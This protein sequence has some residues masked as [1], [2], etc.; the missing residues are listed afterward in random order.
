MNKKG[1][2]YK[3]LW[4]T[5]IR[6]PYIAILFLI[7]VYLNNSL[8]STALESYK[9]NDVVTVKRILYSPNAL[10]YQDPDTLRVYPGIID[11][12]KANQE[13]MD[14]SFS[15]SENIIAAR[16]EIKSLLGTEIMELY[17]NKKWYDRWNPISSFDQFNK[18]IFKR[19]VLIKDYAGVR[20]GIIKI[21]VISPNE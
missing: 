9:I 17:I 10:A 15:I 3:I 7:F 8:T 4:N 6:L 5:I 13:F 14:N 16:I 11:L 1:D 21:H 18:E 19:P 20:L 12:D 2:A